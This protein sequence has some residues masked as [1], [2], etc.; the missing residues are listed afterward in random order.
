MPEYATFSDYLLTDA[1]N[2]MASCVLTGADGP[3]NAVAAILQWRAARDL[4][5]DIVAKAIGGEWAQKELDS[6]ALRDS[7]NEAPK[8]RAGRKPR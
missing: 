6:R 2:V 4:T 7:L 1:E 5:R 8:G 3:Y